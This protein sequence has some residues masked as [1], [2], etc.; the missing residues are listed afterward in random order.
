MGR[1]LS[2]MRKARPVK[3]GRKPLSVRTNSSALQ[4][5]RVESPAH[6]SPVSVDRT[7]ELIPSFDLGHAE[8][9]LQTPGSV[10]PPS[11]D[12]PL[13]PPSLDTLLPLSVELESKSPLNPDTPRP[14]VVVTP[15]PAPVIRNDAG[16]PEGNGSDMEFL[17]RRVRRLH[18]SIGAEPSSPISE[19]LT[20]PSTRSRE[21]KECGPAPSAPV[22]MRKGTIFDV[23]SLMHWVHLQRSSQQRRRLMV[24]L[25]LLDAPARNCRLPPRIK[26]VRLEVIDACSMEVTPSTLA[27]FHGVSDTGFFEDPLQ[28]CSSRGFHREMWTLAEEDV[29]PIPV[30]DLLSSM[31]EFLGVVV[32][33]S[34]FRGTIVCAQ[35][36]PRALSALNVA[37]FVHQ[38][39]PLTG[40]EGVLDQRQSTILDADEWFLQGKFDHRVHNS[41]NCVTLTPELE[42]RLLR[43]HWWQ[44]TTL[45][46]ELMR[47]DRNVTPEAVS[48]FKQFMRGGDN[49]PAPF[50]RK[51]TTDLCE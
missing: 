23:D 25:A 22:P 11:P 44:G 17:M 36:M 1:Y 15:T 13:P 5:E 37:L 39:R 50:T 42:C 41:C 3:C 12:T 31:I 14:V 27:V 10:S 48:D 34:S 24:S 20:P 47:F 18:V 29:T 32:A 40:T 28:C 9:G 30:R 16:E 45:P 35:R 49:V 43:Q 7:P 51:K 2:T 4:A 26:A 46:L 8:L 33:S 6:H 21:T 38:L 19:D